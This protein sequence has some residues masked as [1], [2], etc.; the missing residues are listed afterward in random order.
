ML[1]PW[2]KLLAKIR[3]Y[4]PSAGKRRV[5]HPLEGILRLHSVQLFYNVSDPAMED[6]L[7][8]VEVAGLDRHPAGEGAGRD[9]DPQHSAPE[10]VAV[11]TALEAGVMVTVPPRWLW[12][13]MVQVSML[14][15]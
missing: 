15:P 1:I 12:R 13:T 7:Y 14:S 6:M 5:P 2:E 10:T 3:P 9:D 8:E 4:Y 11:P